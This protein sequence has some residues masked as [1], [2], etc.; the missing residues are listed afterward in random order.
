MKDMLVE[1]CSLLAIPVPKT[2]I[3]KV[4]YC[5]VHR[6]KFLLTMIQCNSVMNVASNIVI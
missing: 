2:N 6:K 1:L 5:S 4:M 3:R